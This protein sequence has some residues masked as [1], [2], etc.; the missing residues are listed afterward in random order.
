M[1]PKEPLGLTEEDA[2]ERVSAG[3]LAADKPL[4]MV[5]IDGVISL[6]GVS[7]L[8]DA[9]PRLAE[10][11]FHSIEGIPHFLSA[12]AAAHLLDLS[13]LF[14]LV[15]ASGWEERANDH[16]PHLLGLPA[17][18]PFLHF[19][20]SV[21]RSNAHWKLDAIEAHAAGRALA[22]VDDALDDECRAWAHARPAPTLLVQ[23]EPQIGLTERE[24]RLLADWALQLAAR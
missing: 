14:E 16:L 11:S 23:T 17:G 13:P 24:A 9:D 21:G 18:L 15:W 6:F 1:R 4:L 3:N 8:V 5:D 2:A 22:W 10:G 12:T 19:S 7:L 20:R